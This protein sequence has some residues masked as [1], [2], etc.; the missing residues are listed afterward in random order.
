VRVVEAAAAHA[1]GAEVGVGEDV[2]AAGDAGVFDAGLRDLAFAFAPH[3]GGAADEFAAELR[4]SVGAADAGAGAAV[5]VGDGEAAVGDASVDGAARARLAGLVED[6]L[7][8]RAAAALD[9]GAVL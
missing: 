5:L 1:G 7:V 2:D 3:L 6:E 8:Q 9:E 4:A